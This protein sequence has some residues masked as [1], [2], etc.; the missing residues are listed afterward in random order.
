MSDLRPHGVDITLQ[1]ESLRLLFPIIVIDEIQAEC[2]AG[3]FDVMQK[4]IQASNMDLKSETIE[5]FEKV[6]ATVINHNNNN[7]PTVTPDEIGD[8]VTLDNYVTISQAL[9]ESFGLSMPESD[10]DDDF[11]DEDE[12][13]KKTHR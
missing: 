2:D 4:I 3:I 8:M 7:F 11:D 1:G 10:E 5:T 13:K 12:V 6:L 9:L